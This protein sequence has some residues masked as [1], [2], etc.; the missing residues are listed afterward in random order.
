ML[1]N[2]NRVPNIVPH[3]DSIFIYLYADMMNNDNKY[4]IRCLNKTKNTT[5]EQMKGKAQTRFS[6]LCNYFSTTIK[7]DC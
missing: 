1:I 6:R 3:M 2:N 4:C 7:F 5:I